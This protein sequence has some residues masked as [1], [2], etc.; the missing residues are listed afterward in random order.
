MSLPIYDGW[1]WSH[2][3]ITL[4]E[5]CPYAFALKY[6]YGEEC[7]QSNF[8][9]GFGSYMHRIHE[10][11]YNGDLK[12]EDLVPYYIEHFS[13]IG[14]HKQRT[15]YF[16]DGLNYLEGGIP[17]IPSSSSIVGVEKKLM[18]KVG[19]YDFTGIIDLLYRNDDETLTIV[20]HK[21][22]T[23]SPR[24]NKKKPTAS[25]RELDEYLKQLYIYAHAVRQLGLGNVQTLTFNCFRG[26][27]IVSER[28]S[29]AK[30]NDAVE[31]AVN[32]IKKIENTTMFYPNDDWFF[33]HNLCDTRGVCEYI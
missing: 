19:E 13:E 24:S 15:K 9:S 29:E 31:W 32:T 18:F 28:Y 26:S 10:L 30:E 22:H 12:S 3:R 27:Q 16:L 8:Y 5:Q 14:S 25:D 1:T 17:I 23:L 33:C 21:S 6:I 20:D 2:S 11:F 7:E 4:F